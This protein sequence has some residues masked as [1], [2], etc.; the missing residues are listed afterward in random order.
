MLLLLLRLGQLG[1][2]Q[3]CVGWELMTAEFSRVL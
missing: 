2:K 1:G 3:D